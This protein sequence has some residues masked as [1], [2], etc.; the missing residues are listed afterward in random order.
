[1]P[2]TYEA[3]AS[4]GSLTKNKTKLKTSKI[5]FLVL[6]NGLKKKIKKIHISTPGIAPI[7]L[8]IKCDATQSP[9]KK[10]H[11]ANYYYYNNYLFLK[12]VR[13]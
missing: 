4:I 5:M 13:I 3:P 1:M 6:S 10:I 12:G 7:R 8:Q 11:F 2:T 9:L